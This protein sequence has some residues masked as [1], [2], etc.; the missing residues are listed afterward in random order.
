MLIQQKTKGGQVAP[1]RGGAQPKDAAINR[2]AK[3]LGFTKEDVRRA[4]KIAG[5]SEEARAEAK[6]LGLD[7]NQRALLQIAKL[8][9]PTAQLLAV[10]EIDERIRAAQARRAAAITAVQADTAAS[11]EIKTI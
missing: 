6:R 8:P 10:K 3:A 9:T 1:P 5:I 11:A 4:K 7:D 2:T